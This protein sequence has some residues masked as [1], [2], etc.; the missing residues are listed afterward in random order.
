MLPPARPAGGLATA[1]D[2]IFCML[3]GLS[4][5]PPATLLRKRKG[6]VRELLQQPN[7]L[8]VR[9]AVLGHG[10]TNELVDFLELLLA[11][12]GFRPVFHQGDYG[13]YYEESVLDP[14]ALVDFRPDVVVL[15]TSSG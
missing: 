3:P 13:R 2:S 9:V 14:S 4:S 10:T 5:L 6:L 8:D 1:P 15:H 12:E 7:L 11:N